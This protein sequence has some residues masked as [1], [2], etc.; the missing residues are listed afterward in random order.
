LT[1]QSDPASE[2]YKPNP[3]VFFMT[4]AI[5]PNAFV[6]PNPPTCERSTLLNLLVVNDDPLVRE[7]CRETATALAYRASACQSAEQAI[8]QIESQPIDVVLLDFDPPDARRL[9][10]REWQDPVV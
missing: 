9:P 3:E 6:P 5:A 1:N 10:S 2:S 7:A 4:T 8:W